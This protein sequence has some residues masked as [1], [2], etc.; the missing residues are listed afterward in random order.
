M[1]LAPRLCMSFCHRPAEK[2]CEFLSPCHAKTYSYCSHFVSLRD[3]I[4]QEAI[5]SMALI[6][7]DK[8]VKTQEPKATKSHK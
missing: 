2:V 8:Y 1:A 7:H 3:R 4:E 6:G 5:R